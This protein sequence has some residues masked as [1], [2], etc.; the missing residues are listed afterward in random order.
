MLTPHELADCLGHFAATKRRAYERAV[1][2]SYRRKSPRLGADHQDRAVMADCIGCGALHSR[3]VD[4]L[5]SHGNRHLNVAPTVA[6]RIAVGH[7]ERGSLSYR[8]PE[9]RHITKPSYESF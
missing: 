1:Q 8:E 2:K 4:L 7:G 3:V 5:L 6:F 9:A